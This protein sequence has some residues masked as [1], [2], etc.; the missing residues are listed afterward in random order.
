MKQ[1][2]QISKLKYVVSRTTYG[3]CDGLLLPKAKV[4]ILI[5]NKHRRTHLQQ[6]YLCSAD[7]IV[8]DIVEYIKA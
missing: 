8:T 6:I 3:A 7:N 5:I 1:I 4:K 2:Q